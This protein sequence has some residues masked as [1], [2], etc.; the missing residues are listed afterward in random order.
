MNYS[1]NCYISLTRKTFNNVSNSSFR[2]LKSELE[3][4]RGISFVKE[5]IK[6]NVICVSWSEYWKIK[7]QQRVKPLKICTTATDQ[8][9]KETYT[10]S[11]FR[12]KCTKSRLKHNLG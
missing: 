10:F 6:G 9:E 2:Y 3:F 1:E 7:V 11:Q 8:E 12:I 5:Q 4:K